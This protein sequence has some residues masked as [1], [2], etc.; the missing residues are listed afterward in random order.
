MNDL[1][2]PGKHSPEVLGGQCESP[3]RR[4]GGGMGAGDP[5]RA[6]APLSCFQDPDF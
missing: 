3:A 4:N 2:A 5:A 6:A 1:R